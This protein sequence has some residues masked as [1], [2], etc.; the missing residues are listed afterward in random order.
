M[1]VFNKLVLIQKLNLDTEDYRV[2]HYTNNN[3]DNIDDAIYLL[4]YIY[5]P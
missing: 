3:E 4:F 5:F 2:L 1:T